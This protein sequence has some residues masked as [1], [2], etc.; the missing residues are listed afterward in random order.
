MAGYSQPIPRRPPPL[1]SDHE[2]ERAVRALRRHFA[3]PAGSKR[4]E[5]ERRLSLAV[6]AR[7]RADLAGLFRDLPGSRGRQIAR[8][9]R[10]LL[11][12]HGTSHVLGNGT[13]IGIW[14]LTGGGPFRPAWA[15]V[16]TT[17]IVVWHA[18]VTWAGRRPGPSCPAR[19]LGER[20]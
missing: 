16:P 13:L 5:L 4:E 9:N 19:G 18:G 14:E 8:V 6:S 20:G 7:T 1:A 11:R 15:L 2:R 17:G 10:V 12:P 3:A